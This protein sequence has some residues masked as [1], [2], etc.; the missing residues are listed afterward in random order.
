MKA[1]RMEVGGNAARTVNAPIS[2]HY[3][4]AIE[5]K[6]LARFGWDED[7]IASKLRVD[8]ESVNLYLML[9][10]APKDVRSGLESGSISAITVL[11]A[12]RASGPACFA[13]LCSTAAP[14]EVP[15]EAIAISERSERA[16][17]TNVYRLLHILDE[18]GEKD[19]NELEALTGIRKPIIVSTL[20]TAMG[21]GQVRCTPKAERM[22]EAGMMQEGCR[23][24]RGQMYSF[25]SYEPKTQIDG[26]DDN[27]EPKELSPLQQLAELMFMPGLMKTVS[28]LNSV[29]TSRK[30]LLAGFH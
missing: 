20:Y 30:V 18:E 2:I 17:R 13:R 10:G 15:T 24:P 16:Q 4:V 27:G 29:C 28:S 12:L 23:L 8:E 19:A 6:L 22:K 11:D 26:H 7:E 1:A 5:C 3:A 25:L 14:V 9:A 21:R